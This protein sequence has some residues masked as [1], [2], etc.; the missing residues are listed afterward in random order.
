MDVTNFVWCTAC[1]LRKINYSLKKYTI[2]N[3][4]C[5]VEEVYIS[6]ALITQKHIK[7]MIVSL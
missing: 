5:F 7:T 4:K 3:L 2:E 6:N 1:S